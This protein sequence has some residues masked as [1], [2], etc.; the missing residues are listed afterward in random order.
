MYL[1]VNSLESQAVESVGVGA[2]EDTE[3]ETRPL[4]SGL[5]IPEALK[6]DVS[7]L[8]PAGFL[9]HQILFGLLIKVVAIIS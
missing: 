7:N 4:T 5:L 1:V 3:R 2:P 8:T 9:K 6:T